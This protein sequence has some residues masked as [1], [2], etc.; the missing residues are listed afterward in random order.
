MLGKKLQ[1]AFVTMKTK[2][3]TKVLGLS[4]IG[5]FA[6]V[7]CDEIVSKP[8]Q[9]EEPLI[10]TPASFNEEVYHN[11]ASVVYDS[12]HDSGIGE[13]VLNQVLYLYSVTA[14]GAYDHNVVVNG[15][16]VPEAEITLTDAV[17]SYEKENSVEKIDSFINSH[18]AYW[19]N[20]SSHGAVTANERERVVAKYYSVKD[21]IAEAMYSKISGGTYS[22]RHIFSEEKF[23]KSLRGSLE[24]VEDPNKDGIEFFE[25]QILPEVEAEDVFGNYLHEEYY[26]SAT[27]TYVTDKVIPT[28]YRELLAEQY[29]LEETYNTLGRSYARKVNI[30]KFAN[31]SNYP[32]AA[33]Y[34]AKE[35]VG[36]INAEPTVYAASDIGTKGV[37]SRF[38]KYSNAYVGVIGALG[39][40]SMI[41]T[42]SGIEKGT[43]PASL[44]DLVGDFWL[45]TSYGDVAEKYIKMKDVATYGVNSEYENTFTNNGAYPSYVGLE[46]EKLKLKEN[47]NTTNGWF[48]KNG[49]LTEL[50]ESVRSRLFNIGV[51]NGVK[52]TAEERA[53]AE[54]TYKDGEWKEAENENAYV[55]RINGHNY[56]KTASRVKGD[57]INNDILHYDADSKAYY[58]IEIEEA[59]SSSK[60]S[61]TSKN[62]YEHTRGDAGKEVMQEIINEVAKIVG[63]GE[64]YS[65]LATKKYLKAMSIEYHDDSVYDYFKSNYPELF[66]EDTESSSSETPAET[67]AE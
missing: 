13:D 19:D 54:R 18:K 55:C 10:S 64:S 29:L 65:T 46:Q 49:G 6:L 8:T 23:L 53:A 21:S 52:E 37:L 56:L 27:N 66:D 30:I 58:I 63:K 5:L 60:L 11:I 57:S 59:V 36:E 26:Q 20:Q 42:A 48:V 62:N 24:S 3:I 31:N 45:G 38:K 16:K 17:E 34:L 25:R 47:D 7:G 2:K 22:D 40:E 43:T 35:L 15:A 4:I 39:D 12:I 44:A 32:N 50:P 1:E 41:L 67:S 33:Y 9:Y 14:F 61:K 51:A 28:I